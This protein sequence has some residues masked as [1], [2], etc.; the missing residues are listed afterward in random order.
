ME[1]VY[2]K[3]MEIGF[4]N[5]NGIKYFDLK[6]RIEETTSIKFDSSLE[7][8]FIKWIGESFESTFDDKNQLNAIISN[9]QPYIRFREGVDIIYKNAYDDF[10]FRSWVIKG[11]TVKQYLDYLELQES[12]KAAIQ[13]KKQSNLSI[14]IAIGAIIISTILGVIS[15]LN[16]PKPP[17]PPYDMK[18]IEDKSGM[19]ELQK[20][21]DSLKNEIYE[22]QMLIESY[23]S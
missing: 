8:T 20:E 7:S 15:I 5:P 19:K 14:W 9:S 4:N 2:I 13:A 21:N 11:A 17:Q 1:N 23:E 22:A 3:S 10:S 16:S 12:R 18:I 6:K